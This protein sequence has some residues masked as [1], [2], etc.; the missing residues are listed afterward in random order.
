MELN[1]QKIGHVHA[2]HVIPPV[3]EQTHIGGLV[4]AQPLYYKAE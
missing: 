3:M 4:E 1:E 2:L